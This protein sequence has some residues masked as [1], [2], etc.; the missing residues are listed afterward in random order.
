[1]KTQVSHIRES[2]LQQ[3]EEDNDPKIK[4]E[5][6]SL[7]TH[8]IW[9]FEFLLAIIIWLELLTIVNEIRKSLQQK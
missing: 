9:N 3:A 4:S 5:D 1:M 2:L 8:E 7:A 6:G